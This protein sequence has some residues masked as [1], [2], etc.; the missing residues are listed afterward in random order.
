MSRNRRNQTPP[1]K[2]GPAMKALLLCASLGTTGVG[3]IWQKDQNHK[4]EDQLKASETAY[5]KVLQEIEK[6][7]KVL[8][9][10]ESFGALD[11][12]IKHLGLGL[13]PAQPGEFVHIVEHPVPPVRPGDPPSVL[14]AQQL[15]HGWTATVEAPPPRR[16]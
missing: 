15:P 5:E 8:A 6:K 10:L 7:S 1:I 3:Y 12:Q 11:A 14:Y 13:V 4:L 9:G 16:P 2:L